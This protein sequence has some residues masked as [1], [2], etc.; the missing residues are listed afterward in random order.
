MKIVCCKCERE[1]GEKRG[2]G[3]THT[4]CD[5]CVEIAQIEI[6]LE[7]ADA[8]A[9]RA[10]QVIEEFDESIDP[11]FRA[12]CEAILEYGTSRI[13]KLKMKIAELNA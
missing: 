4:Y 6:L 1:I 3:V 8:E 9:V 13:A 10:R 11:V 12:T 5:R 2:E 7:Q